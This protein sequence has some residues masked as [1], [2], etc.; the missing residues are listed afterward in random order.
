[1]RK[2]LSNED[3]QDP[4]TGTL[5]FPAYIC[6]YDPEKEYEIRVEIENL[7]ERGTCSAALTG[8]PSA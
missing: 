8:R 4:D 1:M 2:E 5:F 7:K 6:T 3:F